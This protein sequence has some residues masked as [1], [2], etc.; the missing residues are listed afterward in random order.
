MKHHQE[1]IERVKATVPADQLLIF[2]PKDGWKPLCDFLGV[3]VPDGPYPRV[4]EATAIKLRVKVWLDS[5]QKLLPD[6]D[7]YE[8]YMWPWMKE[9][10]E[11]FKN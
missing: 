9:K 6:V 3:P 7:V 4:N 2:N 5:F 8:E 11:D 10:V 1:H